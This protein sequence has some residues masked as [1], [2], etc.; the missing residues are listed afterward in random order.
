[1]PTRKRMPKCPKCGKVDHLVDE[2]LEIRWYD[3]RVTNPPSRY[4]DYE[5]QDCEPETKGDKFE[6]PE[7]EAVLF[8]KEE[9]AKAFLKCEVKHARK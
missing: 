5:E 4:L 3:V 7:C 6:C 1:M 9:E 8:T 2:S